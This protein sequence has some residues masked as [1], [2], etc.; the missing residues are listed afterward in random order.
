LTSSQ[1]LYKNL[2]EAPGSAYNEDVGRYVGFGWKGSPDDV[3]RGIPPFKNS[4]WAS[5]LKP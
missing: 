3:A 2:Q 1:D 4:R 5:F